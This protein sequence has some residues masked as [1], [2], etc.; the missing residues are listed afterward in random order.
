M[1]KGTGRAPRLS[2]SMLALGVFFLVCM[3]IAV[4]SGL[5]IAPAVATWYPTLIK[6]SFT[7]PTWLFAPVWITLYVMIAIAGWRVWVWAGFGRGARALAVYAIQLLLNF[8]WSFLFFGTHAIGLGLIGII[9]LLGA[10]AWTIYEFAQ[11]DRIATLLL[12]PYLAWV[13]FAALLNA[14]IF[15]LN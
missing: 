6:P 14:A 5:L 8:G 10:I 13:S 2:Q 7:P 12:V 3:I 9:A 15:F 11:I 1:P 4:V